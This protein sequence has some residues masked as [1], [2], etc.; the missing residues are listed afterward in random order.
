VLQLTVSLEATAEDG[1]TVSVAIA[2]WARCAAALTADRLV[3]DGG[4]GAIGHCTKCG[5]C[6]EPHRRVCRAGSLL[7]LLRVKAHHTIWSKLHAKQ[8]GAYASDLTR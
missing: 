7:Y 1:E 2:H 3:A 4:E 5:G 6:R 8:L